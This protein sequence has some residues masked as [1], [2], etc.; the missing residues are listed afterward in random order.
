MEYNT[1]R[2]RLVMPEYGRNI[3]KMIDIA[4]KIKNKKKRNK[5]AC[6][7]IKLMTEFVK[8]KKKLIPYFKHILWNQ[9]LIMSN[10]KLDIDLP[11]PIEHNNVIKKHYYNKKIN[12]PK[13]LNDFRYYGKIIRYMINSVINCKNKLK[14]KE[15]LYS[16]ANTMKKNYLRWNKNIVEDNIIFKDLEKLSKGKICLLNNNTPLLQNSK[17]LKKIRIY[18]NNNGNI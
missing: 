5:F 4:I 18:K 10:Y 3:H 15:L 1:N 11:F 7:I 8:Y 6:E 9:L 2:F 16:I 13:Y 14:K 12:Y 17:I